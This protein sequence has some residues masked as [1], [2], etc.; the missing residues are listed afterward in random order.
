MLLGIHT[1]S[2]HLHGF[3]PTDIC[4]SA[5][6]PKAMDIL[7]LMDYALKIGIDGLH[8]TPTDCGGTDEA[9]L[10]EIGRAAREKGLFLEY[11]FSF[12]DPYDPGLNNTFEEAIGN[13]RYLGA[14]VA[15][16]SMDI[17]RP[18]PIGASRFHP[19]VM[20][21][22]ENVVR[23]LKRA[24]PLAEE[25]GIK[26][27]V[28]NH[29]DTFSS[30]VLW[31][32]D[33]VDHANV[34]TCID[35][36]NAMM[37]L[38][39]PMAA[40]ENLVDKA[41]TNHFKDHRIEF[42]QYG[43]RLVGVACGDGDVDLKRAYSLIRERSLSNRIIIEVEYDPGDVGYEKSLRLEKEA[44]EKSVRYCREILGIGKKNS[45]TKNGNDKTD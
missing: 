29:T 3:G 9:N 38:E 17:V 44:L 19:D 45:K 16:V 37:V 13:A 34:G 33:K 15:K 14:D 12:A 40:V 36:F 42:T 39:D 21:Q 28:E 31:V 2:L 18:R 5:A 32:V 26:I 24:A 1:Y 41:F 23:H 10:R 43:A 11:N 8:I 20:R 4:G 30:E 6:R 27:A 35:I 22:L 7:G 25:V